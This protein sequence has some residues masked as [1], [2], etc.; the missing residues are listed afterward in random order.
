MEIE[1]EKK[2]IEREKHLKQKQIEDQRRR[3][4]AEEQRKKAL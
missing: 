4:Y 1:N 3:E 2:R